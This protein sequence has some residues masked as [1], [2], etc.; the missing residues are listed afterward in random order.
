MWA[1][2]NYRVEGGKQ[3]DRE[4]PDD[5]HDLTPSSAPRREDDDH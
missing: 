3:D 5:R 2:E 4:H 1:G